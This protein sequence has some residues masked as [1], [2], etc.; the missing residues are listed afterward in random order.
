MDH[1][2][3]RAFLGKMLPYYMIPLGLV[4]CEEFPRTLSGK[5]DRKAFLPP[6]GLDDWRQLAERYR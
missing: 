2:D 4:R 6:E 1:E 3:F 5:V